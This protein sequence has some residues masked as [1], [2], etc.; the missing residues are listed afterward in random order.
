M[1]MRHAK[2]VSQGRIDKGRPGRYGDGDGLYLQ[3]RSRTAKHWVFRYVR[4][5]TMREMGLGAAI[6]RNAVSLSDAR[7]KAR[8]L[9]DMHRSGLDPLEERKKGR[10]AIAAAA[11]AGN[12]RTFKQAAIDYIELHRAGW[13]N[14]GRNAEQWEGSLTEY[15]YPKL[16]AMDVAVI[17]TPHITDVL[18]PIWVSK[19]ETASRLRSRIEL[20]LSREKVLK[21]RTGENPAR[22]RGHLDAVLPRHSKVKRVKHYPAM[23]AKEIGDFMV[24]VRADDSAAARALEFTIL[25][26]ARSGE[27]LGAKWD[28]LDF[29]KQ[30]WVRPA[31]R[32]KSGKAHTVPLS[33]RSMEILREMQAKR[34]GDLVFPGLGAEGKLPPTA[35]LVKMQRLGVRGYTTHGFRS[36]FSDWC[37]ENT[38]FASEVREMALAHSIGDRT[39]EAYRRG[40]LLQKR[41]ALAEAWS[42]YCSPPV[43]E[44]GKKVVPIRAGGSRK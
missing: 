4:G 29:D 38:N 1:K 17:D 9:W 26:A 12:G 25:T 11:A 6:G 44:G 15:V 10:M 2:G 42:Q 24:K 33:K 43:K 7:A 30:Q 40:D 37:S 23:P 35:L 39:E 14:G 13:R 36:T 19:P 28:E 20:I 31:E 34:T 41:R 16:G 21:N 5:G 18:T 32:M 8:A 3:I 22:W 27:V